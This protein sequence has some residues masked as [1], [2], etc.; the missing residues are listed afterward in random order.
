MACSTVKNCLTPIF[1]P[2]LPVQA[3][4]HAFVSS[5]HI[6]LFAYRLRYKLNLALVIKERE[7]YQTV[8]NKKKSDLDAAS[9]V[10][11]IFSPAW[12]DSLRSSTAVSTKNTKCCSFSIGAEIVTV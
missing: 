2:V 1:Y 4:T 12:L 7:N 9:I 6:S 5:T 3:N 11:Q 8:K 10:G